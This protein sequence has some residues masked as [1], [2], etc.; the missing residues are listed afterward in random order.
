MKV[1]VVVVC[2]NAG[3]ELSATVQSVL[4]QNYED[5]EIII[6]AK[7]EQTNQRHD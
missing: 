6:K 1:S 4:M 2:L 7:T 5:F 3:E